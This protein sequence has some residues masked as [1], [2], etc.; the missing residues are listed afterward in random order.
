MSDTELERALTRADRE[1][2][3]RLP[4]PDWF[5]W[6]KL[7]HMVKRPQYRCDRLVQLGVLETRVVGSLAEANI[8]RQYRLNPVYGVPS[9]T[10]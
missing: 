1:A 3:A 9:A 7:H 10:K 2:L 8:R 6:D 5:D 4:K